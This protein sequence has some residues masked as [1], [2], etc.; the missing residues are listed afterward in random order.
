MLDCTVVSWAA[1][2]L[3]ALH[4]PY[5]C[6]INVSKIFEICVETDQPTDQPTD[7]PTYLFL[8]ALLPIHRN[9]RSIVE[10][11]SHF[12]VKPNNSWGQVVLWLR[13]LWAT[14]E[15]SELSNSE[16]Q[17][18][19]WNK[20]TAMYYYWL[21]WTRLTTSLCSFKTLNKKCV[22]VVKYWWLVLFC[23][24]LWYYSQLFSHITIPGVLGE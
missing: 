5:S 18:I 16:I 12:H 9:V 1:W 10:V 8:D 22:E 2:V 17:W 13:Q 23:S 21:V 20:G 6:P 24:K 15:P 11:Q 4:S 19:Q 3:T 7:R 14:V